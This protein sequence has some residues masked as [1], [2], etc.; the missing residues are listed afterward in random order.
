MQINEPVSSLNQQASDPQSTNTST[1]QQPSN[2]SLLVQEST[3]GEKSNRWLIVGLM[4]FAVV[5][6]GTAGT[7]AYQSYRLRKQSLSSGA[8]PTKV[9]PTEVLRPT[10]TRTVITP[11]P[12]LT[13][14]LTA[15]WKTY[16]SDENGIEFKYPV[17]WYAK[18]PPGWIFQVF[19]ES[20]P[21]EIIEGTG[22]M[23]SIVLYFNEYMNTTTGE[24]YFFEEML[25]DGVNRIK[26][27]Y[28][29]ESVETN[30]LVI[31]EKK[32]VQISGVIGPGML[33]G[34]HFTHTLIQMDG[35]LLVVE[36]TN[37]DFKD[38]YDQILSTLRLAN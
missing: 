2:V 20:R 15:D 16:R 6:L 23:A 11:L 32:A 34:R 7:L 33:E 26:A 5:V 28:S 29:E 1:S 38:V 37:K 9:T 31:G 25:D 35:H 22:F 8:V 27:L 10:P 30:D 12:T 13:A 18:S 24:R 4:V 17:G 21:F 36:L 14:D 19:L 3:Q